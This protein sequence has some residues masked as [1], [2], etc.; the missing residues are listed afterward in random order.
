MVEALATK[1]AKQGPTRDDL[2]GEGNLALCEAAQRFDPEGEI[3]FTTYAY[4]QVR[5]RMQNLIMMYKHNPALPEAPD[6]TEPDEV[7]S[8]HYDVVDEADE[9]EERL[10]QVEAAI[11][12]V[13]TQQEGRVIRMLFGLGGKAMRT[14]E[15]AARLG[16]SVVFVY[17][18]KERSLTKL[19]EA[20]NK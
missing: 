8:N 16:V 13:L 20:M 3:Q 5:R 14:K 4:L 11:G 19:R 17:K 7:D 9:R 15:V 12:E 1:L 10:A 18:A 6:E 2:V